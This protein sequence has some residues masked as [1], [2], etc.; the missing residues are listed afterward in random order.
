MIDFD[1]GTII[2]S[3]YSGAEQ[4]AAVLLD[5]VKYMLKYSEDV[6]ET[7]FDRSYKNNHFSEYIGSHIFEACGFE[8]QKTYLGFHKGLHEKKKMVV[9]C[10]DFTQSGENFSEFG[11]LAKISL[12]SAKRRECNIEDVYELINNL[13]LIKDKDSIKNLFWDMFVIDALIG[14]R[15]RHL[16]NWGLIELEDDLTFAPIYDCGSSLSALADD[17]TMIEGLKNDVKFKN[18]QYN[19]PSVYRLEGKKILYHE[20]FK[21]PPED[22]SQAIKRI[23]PRINMETIKN[24]ITNTEML[25][26]LNKNYIIK[27]VQL[28]YDLIL[29]PALKKILKQEKAINKQ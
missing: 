4:K 23:V 16:G 6:R 26:E 21:N 2:A 14:N 29:K 11:N 10:K 8:V 9:A 15:D 20:I 19:I 22:L 28:R 24:I 27:A 7:R 3:N 13:P 17:S 1:K 12:N 18:D 5:G 25:P